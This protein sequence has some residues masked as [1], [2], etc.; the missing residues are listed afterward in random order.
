MA[1]H[2]HPESK[3]QN[4]RVVLRCRPMSSKEA[5]TERTAIHCVSEKSA[6]VTYSSLGKSAKK[7]FTFDGVYDEKTTQEGMVS[8][9]VAFA[10]PATGPDTYFRKNGS[11]SFLFDGPISDQT[12]RE[13]VNL[14]FA[15]A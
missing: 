4:V 6:E 8:F 2:Q 7:S 13:N 14:S 15:H 12:T 1:D 9:F 11:K 5:Q 10:R 3:G